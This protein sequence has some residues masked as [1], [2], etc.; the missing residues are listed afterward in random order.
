MA[1]EDF[2][3]AVSA[4]Q[5]QM[6]QSWLAQQQRQQLQRRHISPL[7]VIDE[8][9]QRMLGRG[10]DRDKLAEFM[11]ETV[12]RLLYRQHDDRGL[13]PDQQAQLWNDINDD[14][15]IVAQC[16]QQLFLPAL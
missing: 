11:V 4:N 13:F 6:R 3:V 8:D 14:L 5:Q 9:Y 12:L 7:Q 16:L 2:I 1:G 15:R 10:K